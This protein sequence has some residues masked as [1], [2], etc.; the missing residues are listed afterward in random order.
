MIGTS[1]AAGECLRRFFV[2]PRPELLNQAV[3]I[4]HS[5]ELSEAGTAW[6]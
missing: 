1:G 5:S 4:R 3:D 6:S 2:E